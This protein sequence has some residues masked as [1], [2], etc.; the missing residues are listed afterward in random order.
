MLL[1]MFALRVNFW[2]DMWNIVDT[3]IVGSW[4]VSIVM[5][6][7]ISVDPLLFRLARLTRLLRLLRLVRTVQLFDALYLMT[8]AIKASLSTL[9][10]SI[11][12]L[13]LFLVMM[14]LL[15]QKLAEPFILDDNNPTE[16]RRQV[17][18]FYGTFARSMLTM[19]EITLGNWMPPCRALVENVSEWFMLVFL[20]H[21]LVIG[22]SVVSVINAVFVQETFKV[23]TSDDRI[24][25][26]AKE[27]AKK[28]HLKK[29]RDLFH[30]VDEDGSG[31]VTLDELSQAFTD[32]EVRAYV[33]ALDLDVL[34]AKQL[35]S[36]LDADEDSCISVQELSEGM[37]RL[38]GLAK[39]YDVQNLLK[40][41]R[42]VTN[43]LTQLGH[44]L[45]S[46]SHMSSSTEA[47]T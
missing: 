23:A 9:L 27:R 12:L 30:H 18:M 6:D 34:D 32:P 47:T 11:V 33:S 45:S 3:F 16:K 22:F 31:T 37:F 4:L 40:H 20:A 10:W 29:L 39:S 13:M 44:K 2:R 15:L 19:F 35:F 8:T 5:V 46:D 42:N 24:M 14:G 38:R 17:F 21:K 28:T 1:R 26:M 41:V 25:L 43:L 36:M 7:K